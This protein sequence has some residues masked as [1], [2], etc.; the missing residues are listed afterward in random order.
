MQ[1]QLTLILDEQAVTPSA[2]WEMLPPAARARVTVMLA[3]L[4]AAV[5]AEGRDE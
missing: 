4:L 1:G 5:I 2:V 3:R